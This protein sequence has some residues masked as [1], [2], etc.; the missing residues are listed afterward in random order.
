M[1]YSL[2]FYQDLLTQVSK[3][4]PPRVTKL[5]KLLSGQNTKNGGGISELHLLSFI[6]S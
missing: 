6:V 3:I 5:S 2:L 1:H 4:A